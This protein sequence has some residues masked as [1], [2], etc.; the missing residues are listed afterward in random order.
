MTVQRVYESPGVKGVK[1]MA[2]PTWAVEALMRG[3]GSVVDKVPPERIDQIKQRAGQWLDDLPQSAA[4]GVDSVM[5]GARVGKD[6]ID[7]WARRHS[8]LVTP[9]IN[10]S[11]S[12]IEPRI[13]GVPAGVGSVDLVAE[14]FA[15]PPLVT[16]IAV[17]RL[18]RRLNRCA[19]DNGLAILVA[20]NV[21][22]ACLAI[23]M[24]RGGKPLYMHRSQSLRL[25]SGTPVPEAFVPQAT[26]SDSREHVHE[27]GSVDG[28][29]DTDAASLPS[30][31][32]LL[33]VDNGS[34]NP[35]WF[36]SSQGQQATRI[37]L[38]MACGGLQRPKPDAGVD[39]REMF[40][41]SLRSAAELLD[42]DAE[43]A[44]ADLVIVPGDGVLGGPSCGL[45][46]GRKDLVESIGQSAIWRTV[47]ASVAITAMMTHA[48]ETLSGGHA[49]MHPI[50]SMLHTGEENLRSR[51]ER[52]ATRVSGDE[53]VRTCQVSSAP[54][55]LTT[56]GPW[57]IA[58]RQLRLQHQTKSSESWARQLAEGVPAVL[59][60]VDGDALVID[61]R[62]VPPSDDGALAAAIVGQAASEA[63]DENADDATS[64]STLDR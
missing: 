49:S 51:A 47:R 9:V 32:L 63:I 16:P 17:D 60:T 45:I 5:R 12:L 46:I 11:G 25:P 37:V 21:D 54:A 42:G 35:I 6:M 29:A 15:S 48:L 23:G 61:L 14:A 22:A 39:L 19:G 55:S 20:S 4:R 10:A 33:A 56:S 53:S 40:K 52:L 38:M 59:T 30:Q 7:R 2:I 1:T 62:W 28:I 36:R 24:T 31:A 64:E 34:S 3:V 58:S 57:Q 41:P 27:V 26:G 13:Q 18:Q 50:L 43:Q 44:C 8:A